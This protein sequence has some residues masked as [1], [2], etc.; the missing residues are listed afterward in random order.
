MLHDYWLEISPI[1]NFIYN[2]PVTVTENITKDF[3]ELWKLYTKT[4][5]E[6]IKNCVVYMG[7]ENKLE[8]SY[9]SFVYCW[10]LHYGMAHKVGNRW[11][12]SVPDREPKFD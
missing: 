8:Q 11:V 6:N 2:N 3:R 10:E 5:K 7:S 4:H 12:Y 1:K 9:R